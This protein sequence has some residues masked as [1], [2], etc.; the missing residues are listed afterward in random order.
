MKPPAPPPAVPAPRAGRPAPAAP[1][2]APERPLPSG[3]TAERPDQAPFIEEPPPKEWRFS[4]SFFNLATLEPVGLADIVFTS[5]LSGQRYPTGT[6]EDGSFVAVLPPSPE[7]YDMAFSCPGYSTKFIPDRSPSLKRLP[8]SERR[9]LAREM[10]G[11]L[12]TKETFRPGRSGR[13]RRDFAAIPL[14]K[15]P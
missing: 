4:G 11:L 7:G 9:D 14:P 6:G 10:D 8:E 2:P 3:K 1:S 12:M 13:L 15:E 5:R